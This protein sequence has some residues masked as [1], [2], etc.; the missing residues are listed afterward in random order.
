MRIQL[1][2]VRGAPRGSCL[3]QRDSFDPP[4]ISMLVTVDV[5]DKHQSCDSWL[6]Y[7][8]VGVVVIAFGHLAFV[9]SLEI[10]YGFSHCE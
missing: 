2:S 9:F 5:K 6:A 10:F 1:E 4:V 3:R 8:L 7:L